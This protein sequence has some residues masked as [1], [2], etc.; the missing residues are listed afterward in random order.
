MAIF[1][2]AY[3][4]KVHM[5]CPV[6]SL[7]EGEKF[8][9]KSPHQTRRPKVKTVSW[10]IVTRTRG[11]SISKNETWEMSMMRHTLS[12][13]FR[14]QICRWEARRSTKACRN[15]NQKKVSG[16]KLRGPVKSLQTG[17]PSSCPGFQDIPTWKNQQVPLFSQEMCSIPLAYFVEGVADT[18][19]FFVELRDKGACAASKYVS[20]ILHSNL[21]SLYQLLDLQSQS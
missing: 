5:I 13:L 1:F 11:I 2:T 17:R 8:F 9:L 7:S 6:S 15:L 4:L 16:L 3:G 10:L 14:A 21:S 19:K 18:S 12:F 20:T